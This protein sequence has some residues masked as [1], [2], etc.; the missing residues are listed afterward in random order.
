MVNCIV[1]ENKDRAALRP[2]ELLEKEG[3]QNI[4]V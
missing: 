3:T 2:Y 1:T 4:A